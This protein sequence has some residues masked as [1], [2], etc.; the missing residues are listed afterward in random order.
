MV[1]VVTADVVIVG[2]GALGLSVAVET[3]LRD[4]SL[5]IAVVGP[6]AHPGSA[7]VAAGAMLNCFA[8]VTGRTGEHPASRAKF[9]LAREAA[10]LWPGW[11]ERLAEVGRDVAVPVGNVRGTLVVLGARST[12]DGV[13]SMRAI[14]AAAEE[15]GEPCQDVDPYG[16]GVLAAEAGDQPVDALYLEN[17]GAVDARRVLASLDAAA[18]G[19]GVTRVAGQVVSLVT[20]KG[21]VTGVRLPSGAMLPAGAVVL[22]A[23][24]ASGRLIEQ[25]PP[26]AV[27][28]M[29]NGTG[30]ALETQRVRSDAVPYVVRTPTLVGGCGLHAVPLGDG[31]E[32]LGATNHVYFDAPA[33]PRL[34]VVQ[35]LLS[36]YTAQFDRNI[37][38]SAVRRW[39]YGLRPVTL[40]TFPLLG[41]A[42]VPRLFFA[43]GT[44]RDGFHS[45]PAIARHLA[46]LLTAGAA[47]EH[48]PYAVF[49]PGR[50]PIE[51]M[52]VDDAAERFA[53]MA[54]LIGVERGM[55]LPYIFGT[56][57]IAAAC[58]Q[59][60]LECVELLG[61]PV[62]LAPEVLGAVSEA[63]ANRIRQV[64]G[65]LSTVAARP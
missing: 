25:L 48:D 24:A 13:G 29:L 64:A 39:Y 11:L 15:H 6:E 34:G 45:A 12:G 56:E 38:F 17:E 9:A 42:P 47:P 61:V 14:R 44:Y 10:R 18:T 57:P 26:G 21:A 46:D 40:D 63:D 50:K 28:P 7:S 43:T 20:A 4:R 22:A 16:I 37:A 59:K 32:Y 3:A 23:G 2:N 19:L 36:G 1:M 41:R 35:A 33:G 49:A 5:R 54:L 65:Y 52:T 27:Q 60:A 53:Q 51:T 62:A 58:R 31:V 8:E 55:R 30:V